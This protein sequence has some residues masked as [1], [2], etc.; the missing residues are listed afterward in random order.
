ML[1]CDLRLFVGV[2]KE[3]TRFL[4]LTALGHDVV[5]WK[6]LDVREDAMQ[7]AAAAEP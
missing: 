6:A 1:P 4:E 2:V 7:S 5:S 3:F